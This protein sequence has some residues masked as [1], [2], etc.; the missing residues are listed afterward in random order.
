MELVLPLLL[1]VETLHP[2]PLQEAVEAADVRL[3]G[4]VRVRRE[5][6]WADVVEARAGVGFVVG[7]EFGFGF[8]GGG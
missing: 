5:V 8:F 2:L 1:L 7:F 3:R 6:A 4:Y